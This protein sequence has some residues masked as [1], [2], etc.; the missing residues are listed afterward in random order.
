MKI[1]RL[2]IVCLIVLGCLGAG[3]YWY[4]F[5]AGAA[6]PIQK[7]LRIYLD[8]G[9]Q[10]QEFLTSTQAFHQRLNQL[11]IANQFNVFPGGHGIIGDDVGWN[12]WH[13]HLFNSLRYVGQQFNPTSARS[14]S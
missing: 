5:I 10:D 9:Q 1:S 8:A 13:K 2:A 3:G 14:S 6:Q 12:Y 4:V 7:H 11:G